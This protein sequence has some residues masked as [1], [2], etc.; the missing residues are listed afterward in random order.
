MKLE[1]ENYQRIFSQLKASP[2]LRREL[3]AITE[4]TEQN[5][6]PQKF[7]LRRL[8]VVAVIMA[9]AVVLTMAVNA[10][11]GGELYEATIGRLVYTFVLN[12][13]GRAKF[14]ENEAFTIIEYPEDGDKAILQLVPG[15]EPVDPNGR[16]IEHTFRLTEDGEVIEVYVLDIDG[17][18][19]GVAYGGYRFEGPGGEGGTPHTHS[20][21]DENGNTVETDSWL[22]A[23]EGAKRAAEKST[24]KSAENS[25]EKAEESSSSASAK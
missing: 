16:I 6:K 18:R 24:E 17:A 11:T 10:A 1:K 13:G 2:E 25:A 19:V 9:L 20:Y 7:V 3:F 14:Y 4:N 22:E 8:T 5:R 21:T 23:L 12:D 15:K